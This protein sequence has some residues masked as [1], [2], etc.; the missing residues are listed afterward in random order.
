MKI[1]IQ[2][3]LV[4]GFSYLAYSSIKEYLKGVED[5]H[6]EGYIFLFGVINIFLSLIFIKKIFEKP[7]Q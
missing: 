5:N 1:K 6:P 3:L 2:I 7:K 4:V